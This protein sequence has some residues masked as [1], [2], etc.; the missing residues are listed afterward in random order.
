ML[1]VASIKPQNVSAGSI[2]VMYQIAV[3]GP[4]P[5][6]KIVF[7]SRSGTRRLT[8]SRTLLIALYVVGDIAAI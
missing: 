7:G 4:V 8:S 6:S 2:G 3:P 5:K 1:A